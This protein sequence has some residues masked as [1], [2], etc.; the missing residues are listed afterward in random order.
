MIWGKP[1]KPLP[2]YRHSKEVSYSH[3]VYHIF[4]DIV[5]YVAFQINLSFGPR[6]PALISWISEKSFWNIYGNC[7]DGKAIIVHISD[8]VGDDR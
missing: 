1:S 8:F 3:C 2:C 4:I 7:L 5:I 6:R